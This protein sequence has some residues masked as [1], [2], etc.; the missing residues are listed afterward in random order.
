MLPSQFLP[1]FACLFAIELAIEGDGPADGLVEAQ[2]VSGLFLDLLALV[3]KH[4]DNISIKHIMNLRCFKLRSFGAS[5]LTIRL[6]SGFAIFWQVQGVCCYRLPQFMPF[7]RCRLTCFRW[8]LG[9][10]SRE[11]LSSL[12]SACVSAQWKKEQVH[13]CSSLFP[14]VAQ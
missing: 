6:A 3:T 4:L 1:V 14:W 9:F 10:P 2:V 5:S 8:I 11:F 13:S 7:I 12:T